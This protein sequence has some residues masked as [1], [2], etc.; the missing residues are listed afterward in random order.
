MRTGVLVIIFFAILV[1]MTVGVYVFNALE[2]DFE[3]QRQKN[4]LKALHLFLGKFA[5]H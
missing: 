1:Y 4:L 5:L 2:A 3:I